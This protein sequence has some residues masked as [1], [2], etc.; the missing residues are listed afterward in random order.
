[1]PQ[2]TAP[3]AAGLLTFRALG[4]SVNPRVRVLA[5]LGAMGVSG[6]GITFHSIIQNQVGFNRLA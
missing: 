4:N 3:I 1:M 5:S 6:V 2:G